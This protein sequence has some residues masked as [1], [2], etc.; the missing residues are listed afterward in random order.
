MSPSSRTPWPALLAALALTPLV[1]AADERPNIIMV[2]ADD[3]AVAAVG[4]Y[5]SRLLDT[6]SI[7]RLADEGLL[8]EN[9]F[10]TNAICAPARAVVLTGNH[11]HV[12]GV[13]DNGDTFDGERQTFPKLLQGAGYQTALIGKWHLK[14]DPTGFDH[15]EVLPGQGDY[16][17][18]VLVT[19]EGKRTVDGYVTDILTDQ[20]LGWLEQRDPERPFLLMLQNKAP[21]RTWMPGPDQLERFVHEDLP[22]PAT[23]L[24]DWS[25]R[26]TAAHEQEMTI[27]RHMFDAYDLKLPLDPELEPQGPDRWAENIL[28]RMNDEQRAAWDATFGPENEAFLA[29]PPEGDELVRWKYQRYIKNYIRCIA[30]IDDNLGRLLDALDA[31]GLSDNTIVVYTSDQ[32]FFLGEQGWYDKRFMDEPALRFPLVVRWPGVIEPGSRATQLVQNLDLAPS[33]LAAAG[34]TEIP[35]P[36]QGQ[37]LLPILR[38]ESPPDWRRSIYYEY[39]ERGIHAVSPH[40]GV[41]TDRYKLIAWPEHD[42]WELFDLQADPHE[43]RSLHDD[44]DLQGV[45]QRLEAELLALRARHEVPE[46]EAADPGRTGLSSL[47]WL[48]GSWRGDLG[49]VIAEETWSLPGGAIMLGFH[50]DAPASG[51]GEAFFEQLRIHDTADGLVYMASPAGRPPTPFVLEQSSPGHVVFANPDHD[52][53]KRIIYRL[54][55]PDRLVA[56]IEGDAGTGQ[57]WAWDLVDGP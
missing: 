8:F 56:R 27:A 16:Y 24:T 21:H 7:D 12:N 42:E 55:G 37:S 18:P 19:P 4:A 50:R 25:G 22:E 51:D 23:L 3:H 34:V 41:R 52:F 53:P 57:E 39:F 43:T 13:R 32:G 17:S 1:H 45:R 49:P 31:T 33:F 30:G 11:S 20:A 14:S 54:D 2:Y 29:D 10:C 28:G 6:P 5:G 15:W 48:A 40:Y 38:G 35:E 36:M 47:A 44:P 26:G 46:P 9:A